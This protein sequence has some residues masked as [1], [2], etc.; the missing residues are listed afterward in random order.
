[1]MLSHWQA[2]PEKAGT[3]LSVTDSG[4]GSPSQLWC[5]CQLQPASHG[6]RHGDSED[7]QCAGGGLRAGLSR[8]AAR[9]QSP[10]GHGSGLGLIVRESTESF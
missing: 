3:A 9:G 5:Q 1:M 4:S 2:G 8:P 6:D 7:C 10:A